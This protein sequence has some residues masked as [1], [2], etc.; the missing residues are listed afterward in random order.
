MS[1]NEALRQVSRMGSTQQTCQKV[2][3]P[4]SPQ[5]KLEM[6]KDIKERGNSYFRKGEYMKATREY[7]TVFCFTRGL[8]GAERMRMELLSLKSTGF[9]DDSRLEEQCMELEGATHCNLA[10]VYLKVEEGRKV[11]HHCAEA[12]RINKTLW[13]AHYREGLAFM[14]CTDCR[15]L[16][17]AIISFDNALGCAPEDSKVAIYASQEK[18]RLIMR[19]ADARSDKQMKQG[20]ARAFIS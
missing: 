5:S 1:N 3:F 19:K 2:P 9:E 4:Q 6:A 13:K 12:L 8:S 10:Q 20:M 7:K 17:R 14:D 15:N 11:L 16:S 18:C